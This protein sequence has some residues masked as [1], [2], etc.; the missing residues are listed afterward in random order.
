MRAC[1]ASGV[2]IA[3]TVQGI[4]HLTN[5]VEGPV[6]YIAPIHVEAEALSCLTARSC[7]AVTQPSPAADPA[8]WRLGPRRYTV[9]ALPL[10]QTLVLWT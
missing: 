6:T 2:C 7:V 10:L 8:I 3:S 1:V 4:V 5:G 9:K